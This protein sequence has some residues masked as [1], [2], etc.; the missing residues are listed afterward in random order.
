MENN[1]K[2]QDGLYEWLV[3]L[4]GMF[5]APNTFMRVMTHVYALL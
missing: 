2:T 5:N 3:M 4:L 1:F